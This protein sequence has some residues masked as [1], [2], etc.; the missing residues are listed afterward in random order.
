MNKTKIDKGLFL[1]DFY[2]V[3]DIPDL[4]DKKGNPTKFANVAKYWGE[5]IPTKDIEVKELVAKGQAITA[6]ENFSISQKFSSNSVFGGEK[7][8]SLLR[9]NK[10]KVPFVKLG[11]WKHDVYGEVK[12]TEDDINQLISNFNK[13]VTGFKPYLTL[14]HLDEEHHSTDSHRKRGELEDIIVEDDIAYGIFNVPDNIY[15]SVL[16]GEY[17]YS[18]GEFNR[19]FT[20]KDSGIN[21]G[22]TVI[23]VAL[24]NSPFLPFG[25]KKVQVLSESAESCPETKENYVF[26]LSLDTSDSKEV[27]KE[28]SESAKEQKT[29]V[30]NEEK[31]E[32]KKEVELEETEVKTEE[33]KADTV[34]EVPSKSEAKEE[35]EST[36][37]IE[38]P[39]NK[40]IQN[41]N[42]DNNKSIMSQENTKIENQANVEETKVDQATEPKQE[43]DSTKLEP[44]DETVKVKESDALK[45]D[46]S[47]QGDHILANLTSQLE[48]VQAMYQTQL[49]TANKTIASLAD[50]VEALTSKL[51]SHDQVTQAFSASMN[52]AQERAL[53][54]KLQEGGL[55]PATVSKFLTF[56][57]AFE[58]SENKNIVKFS[59][60]AGSETKDVEYKVVD[61]VADILLSVSSET[62]L[63]EQ[64][65][66]VSAGRKTGTFDF[67]S[68]IEKNKSAAD[69][70]QTN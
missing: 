29:I 54:N 53:I 13:N 32:P 1:Q 4:V 69:K 5:P 63:V 70:L 42:I 67:S 59:V 34:P 36:S 30:S 22:T 68:I 25:E 37:T 41:T 44:A 15:E 52:Q 55:T 24:T 16:N 62:P 23:R 8:I 57:N 43:A 11:S 28:V 39:P 56:K 14:G 38:T 35:V 65:L 6:T 46:K 61:A 18:S 31:V 66:G 10:V 50:K 48:K 40:D 17:D 9:Q 2:G 12:F 20:D 64:Q 45:T 19:R 47:N 21:L 33:V 60:G 51:N 58:G 3:E 27:S 26:L 49:D 7:E